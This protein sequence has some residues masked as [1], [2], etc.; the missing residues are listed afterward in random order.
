MDVLPIRNQQLSHLKVAVAKVEGK[1]EV[2]KRG[3]FKNVGMLLYIYAYYCVEFL[4]LL[5]AFLLKC[6]IG[7]SNIKS[8]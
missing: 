1:R 7:L 4:Y 2:V 8:P 3:L 5:A 6:D